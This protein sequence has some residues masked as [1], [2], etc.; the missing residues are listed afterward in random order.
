MSVAA[1]RRHR[2]GNS[3]DGTTSSMLILESIETK[4][5]MDPCSYSC[6]GL[7]IPKAWFPSRYGMNQ[8][9]DGASHSSW[10]FSISQRKPAHEA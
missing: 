7:L 8:R 3:V 2:Y 5:A 1:R 9:H 10:Y 4:K 6:Y